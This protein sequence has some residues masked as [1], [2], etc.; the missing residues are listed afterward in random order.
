MSVN[1]TSTKAT[2]SIGANKS[3]VD[4]GSNDG[5]VKIQSTQNQIKTGATYT[6]NLLANDYNTLKNKPSIEDVELKGNKT[7]EELGAIRLSNLEIE[8]LLNAQI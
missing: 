3:K 4:F 1:V 6:E 2:V 5:Q 7:F 8:Q